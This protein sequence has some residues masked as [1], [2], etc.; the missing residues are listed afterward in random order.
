MEP[1]LQLLLPLFP[2]RGIRAAP[3]CARRSS[4]AARRHQ[5]APAVLQPASVS[6]KRAHIRVPMAAIRSAIR[7]AAPSCRTPQEPEPL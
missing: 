1:L 5:T 7:S 3:F 6:E 4:S 2:R